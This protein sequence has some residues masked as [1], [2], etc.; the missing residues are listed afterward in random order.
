M[1]TKLSGAFPVLC[2]PF[3]PDGSIDEADFLAVIDFALEAGA[4]GLVYPG[5]ASEVDTLTPDERRSQV[6]LLAKRVAG[7]VPL[8]IGAS[9]PD[10]AA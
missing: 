6:A 9:D 1:T 3:R 7:R 4:D 2:T 8:V 10:P 5:V